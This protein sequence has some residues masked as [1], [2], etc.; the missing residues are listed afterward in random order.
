MGKSLYGCVVVAPKCRWVDFGLGY[1]CFK[2]LGWA[3]RKFMA[4]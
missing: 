3:R 1:K 2:L 4:K